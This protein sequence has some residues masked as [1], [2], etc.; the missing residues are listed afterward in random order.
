MGVLRMSVQITAPDQV[1]IV[2][3]PGNWSPK[4]VRAE[5]N[6][7]NQH[8]KKSGAPIHVVVVGGGEAVTTSEDLEQL[9][10]EAD[11]AAEGEL[12]DA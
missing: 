9:F 7:I 10:D 8:L 1:A 3:V 5:Q 4:Q 11:E 2:Q 12:E 6:R